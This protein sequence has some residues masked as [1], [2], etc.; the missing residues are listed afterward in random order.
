MRTRLALFVLIAIRLTVSSSLTYASAEKLAENSG[1]HIPPGWTYIKK[2]S[3]SLLRAHADQIGILQEV[4]LPSHYLTAPVILR[5]ASALS[6]R[7][8]SAKL[9]RLEKELAAYLDGRKTKPLYRSAKIIDDIPTI[10]L[11]MGKPG[12]GLFWVFATIKEDSILIIAVDSREAKP[13]ATAR[14]EFFDM[15][16][17]FQ[18]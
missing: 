17:A 10:E 14:Q 12:K 7:T 15:A 4:K 16:R 1:P 13:V 6:T 2:T 8:S 5:R 11:E 18:P 9:A 3:D